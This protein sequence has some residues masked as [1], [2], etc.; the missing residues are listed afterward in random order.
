MARPKKQDGIP[1]RR[2]VSGGCGNR[3]RDGAQR[4]ESTGTTDWQEVQTRLRE[5]L[6][7]PDENVSALVR[8]GQQLAFN[9]WA[10]F[11]LEHYSRPPFRSMKMHAVNQN[12]FKQLKPETR[13]APAVEPSGRGGAG[14]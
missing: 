1:C 14:F 11:F 4:L 6:Q 13:S 12:A 10:D 9:E 7:A 8:R 2:G 3:D 5:R